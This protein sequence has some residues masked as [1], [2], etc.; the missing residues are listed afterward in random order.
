MEKSNVFI[1]LTDII[2]WD[3]YMPQKVYLLMLERD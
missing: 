2:K 1:L 3:R